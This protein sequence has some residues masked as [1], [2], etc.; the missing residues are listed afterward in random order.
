MVISLW[1]RCFL[2]I[3]GFDSGSGAHFHLESVQRFIYCNRIEHFT[4]MERVCESQFESM[5]LIINL[6]YLYDADVF[7]QFRVLIRIQELISIRYQSRDS[8]I[9]I[10]LNTLHSWKEYVRVN[11]ISWYNSLNWTYLYD[12]DGFFQFRVLIRVQELFSIRNQ[13]RDS[14]IVIKLNTYTLGKSV[15][16]S[17]RF[18]GI[19]RLIGH[20]SMMQMISFIA[21]FWF[22]FRSSFPFGISPEIHLL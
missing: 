5:V 15:W 3:S 21:V 6:S 20:I 19:T 17:I 12:A 13:S 18:C 22:G 10:K 14:F 16:E 11:S 2:S 1:C 9:V 8:F 4:L 7:L